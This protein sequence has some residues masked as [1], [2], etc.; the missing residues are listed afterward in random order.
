MEEEIVE[1]SND[2][3]IRNDTHMKIEDH[4]NNGNNCYDIEDINDNN[5]YNNDDEIE[6][7]DIKIENISQDDNNVSENNEENNNENNDIEDKENNDKSYQEKRTFTRFP[8]AKIKNIIKMNPDVKLCVKELYP[9]LGKA[10]ELLFND[11]AINT[12]QIAKFHKRRT[13]NPEDVCKYIINT[14]L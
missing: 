7:N 10:T 12:S 6:K 8:I 3:K 2:I 14:Y 9:L 1:N 5:I 4:D 11:L 13:L